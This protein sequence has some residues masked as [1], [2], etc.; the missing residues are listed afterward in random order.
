VEEALGVDPSWYL[1]IMTPVFEPT[2]VALY[3]RAPE[4]EGH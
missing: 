4:V 1:A 3:L 2:P